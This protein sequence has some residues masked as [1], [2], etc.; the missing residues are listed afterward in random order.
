[1][2]GL[3]RVSWTVAIYK[4]VL[5]EHWILRNDWVGIFYPF[6][7]DDKPVPKKWWFVNKHVQKILWRDFTK[8]TTLELYR[9]LG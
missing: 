9:V 5:C 7:M 3:G 1:M 4:W 2:L 8:E 6:A